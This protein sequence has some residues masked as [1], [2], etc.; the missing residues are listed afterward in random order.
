M[1]RITR[2]FFNIRGIRKNCSIRDKK[3]LFGRS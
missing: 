1:S 2:I 3:Y